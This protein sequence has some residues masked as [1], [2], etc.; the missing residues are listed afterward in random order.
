MTHGD[1]LPRR[2]KQHH[3]TISTTGAAVTSSVPNTKHPIVAYWHI[4]TI[5]TGYSLP[6]RRN[7]S[8]AQQPPCGQFS[9]TYCLVALEQGTAHR[10]RRDATLLLG[11][12]L[13]ARDYRPAHRIAVEGIAQS[14]LANQRN[15]T[16]GALR[17]PKLLS[18]RRICK[19]P[20][21]EQ[22]RGTAA[23]D[24]PLCSRTVE[25]VVQRPEA[26]CR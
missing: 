16:R 23:L 12:S 9:S 3:P 19:Q 10:G 24:Q 22:Q 25:P 8:P 21:A 7:P 5:G 20:F 1:A 13:D 6:G 18:S 4:P 14:T 17:T 2:R 26:P 15:P 11:S